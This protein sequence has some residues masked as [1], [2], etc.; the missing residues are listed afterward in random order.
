MLKQ[1]KAL[2]LSKVMDADDSYHSEQNGA[3]ETEEAA[4]DASSGSLPGARAQGVSSPIRPS[5][6]ST[7]GKA[8]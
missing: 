7:F 8:I 4:D 2:R 3:E 5:E 1:I 6:T